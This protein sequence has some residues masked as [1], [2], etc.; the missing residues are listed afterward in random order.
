MVRMRIFPVL[1]QHQARSQSTQGSDEAHSRVFCEPNVR[2]AK[3]E[4]LAHLNTENVCRRFSLA[5]PLLGSTASSRF[6][7]GQVENARTIALPGKLQQ[8]PA[9]RQ[10]DIVGMRCDGKNV[11]PVLFRHCFSRFTTQRR[12]PELIKDTRKSPPFHLC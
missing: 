12:H 1:S 3:V 7:T 4:V 2:V 5:S 9:S 10:F 6:T 8:S 11:E